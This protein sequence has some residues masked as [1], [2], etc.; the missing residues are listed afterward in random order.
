MRPNKTGGLRSAKELYLGR[1]GGTGPGGCG[2]SL[3]LPHRGVLLTLK[4]PRWAHKPRVC[5]EVRGPGE[6][7]VCAGSFSDPF[8][9]TVWS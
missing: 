7:Q 8:H 6:V 2:F 1:T 5:R 9:T 3:W 4:G